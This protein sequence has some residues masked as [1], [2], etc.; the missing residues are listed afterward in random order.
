MILVQPAEEEKGLF[1]TH[2]FHFGICF[3]GQPQI[4]SHSPGRGFAQAEQQS[5]QGLPTAPAALPAAPAKPCDQTTRGNSASRAGIRPRRAGSPG[6]PIPGTPPQGLTARAMS[7][8]PGGSATPSPS[9]APR[10]ALPAAVPALP[11]AR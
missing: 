10:A 8:D 11:P 1:G 2:L 6:D 4:R 9:R 5:R 3:A 7:A